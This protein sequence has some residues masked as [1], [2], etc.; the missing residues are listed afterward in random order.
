MNP[1]RES[2]T[3]IIDKLQKNI[4]GT[5]FEDFSYSWQK[6]GTVL[7]FPI[8]DVFVVNKSSAVPVSWNKLFKISDSLKKKLNPY[9][10]FRLYP[11]P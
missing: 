5:Q 10:D 7:F 2:F 4:T 6:E 9:S 3:R 11:N 8:N 1:D